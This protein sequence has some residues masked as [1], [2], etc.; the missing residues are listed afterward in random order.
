MYRLRGSIKNIRINIGRS[1]WKSSSVLLLTY[2]WRRRVGPLAKVRPTEKFS[3]HQRATAFEMRERET[4]TLNMQRIFFFSTL[5]SVP[6]PS[7]HTHRI[8]GR[9]VRGGLQSMESA[10]SLC[11]F[12]VGV[13]W[14]E[15]EWMEELNNVPCVISLKRG[16]KEQKPRNLYFNS[17]NFF[18]P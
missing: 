6:S 12:S 8:F 14:Q 13:A 5:P 3:H 9:K 7:T 11:V 4:L 1:L 16:K 17:R 2:A 10:L 18:P 15:Q